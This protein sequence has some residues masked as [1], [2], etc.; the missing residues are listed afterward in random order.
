MTEADKLGILK[1]MTGETNS[2]LL[3]AYLS[4]AGAKILRRLYPFGVPEGVTEV[5]QEYSMNQID[6]AVY[7]WNKRGAE[8]QISH[9]ENGISRTYGDADVPGTMLRDIV[10]FAE[11]V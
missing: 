5:P 7:L 1:S 6:I 2:D 4:L 11:V 3:F 10:P 9:S 8:G